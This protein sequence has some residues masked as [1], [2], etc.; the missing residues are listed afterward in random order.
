MSKL[1][2]PLIALTMMSAAAL[3]VA[4]AD[5]GV[6]TLAPSIATIAGETS[7]V[8]QARTCARRRACGPRGCVWRTV[9][10]RW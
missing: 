7:A 5:A 2:L 3:L 1:L 6:S 4:R 8:E 10:R 9:C